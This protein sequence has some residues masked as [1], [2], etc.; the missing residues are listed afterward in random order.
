[1][2]LACYSGLRLGCVMPV[3]NVSQGVISG[4]IYPPPMSAKL[5]TSLSALLLQ[6]TLGP[7]VVETIAR[8]LRNSIPAA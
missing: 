7:D 2:K 1:M 3:V 4:V 6:P 5:R 8:M